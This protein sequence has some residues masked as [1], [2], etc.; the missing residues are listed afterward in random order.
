MEHMTRS[1]ALLA[2]L[3]SACAT[4]DPV[5]ATWIPD[6]AWWEGAAAGGGQLR[7]A[8]N[9]VRQVDAASVRN[10]REAQLAIQ[11]QSGMPVE[12]ALA[13]ADG[14]NAFATEVNGKATIGITLDLLNALGS[15]RDALA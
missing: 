5:K 7:T 9:K 1:L 11:K 13:E 6:S 2:L 12:L 10:L 3:L 8:D 14:P 4:S 15:D